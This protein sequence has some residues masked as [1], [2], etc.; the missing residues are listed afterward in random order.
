ML[1]RS[2]A[3]VYQNF[4]LQAWKQQQAADAKKNRPDQL[5][6]ALGAGMPSEDAIWAMKERETPSSRRKN[7]S[8]TSVGTPTLRRQIRGYL[9]S[10]CVSPMQSKFSGQIPE[11]QRVLQKSIFPPSTSTSSAGSARDLQVPDS[12][13]SYM[14]AYKGQPYADPAAGYYQQQ[15]QYYP[16]TMPMSAQMPMGMP[17][18][19]GAMPSQP[20]GLYQ[21]Q[22]YVPVY[23]PIIMQQPMAMPT[24]SYTYP[25]APG[26]ELLTGRV[27]FF[28]AAQNYGF[29]T[30]D[31]NGTDLFVH[32]DDFLKAGI[33]KDYIQMSK[34]MNTR[35]AFRR[36]N[37]YGKYSL[38]SKAVDIQIIQ[39]QAPA[40]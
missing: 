21:P 17:P 25:P 13:A 39:D 3:P 31:C 15:Q 14:E 1:P 38:S 18:G 19:M 24:P 23:I 32:Y 28:D 6:I 40:R 30:L 8:D 26:A 36:V 10:D 20:P 33:T 16:G 11:T 34:A 27:K 22:T 37:Y 35:F 4:E 5:K 29:F 7:V 9:S 12:F 2:H